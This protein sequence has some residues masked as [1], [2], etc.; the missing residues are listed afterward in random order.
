MM[1]IETMM[2]VR[3]RERRVYMPAR[4]ACVAVVLLFR[5][6]LLLLLSCALEDLEKLE[7]VD[8]AVAVVVY[9]GYHFLELKH[10]KGRT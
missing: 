6:W 10:K 3:R 2:M 9:D 1:V 7:A 4:A 5:F 8:L